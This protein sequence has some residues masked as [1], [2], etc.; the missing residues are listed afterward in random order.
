MARH[1]ARLALLL[2]TLTSTG[3]AAD[4][5]DDGVPDALDAY[6]CDEALAGNAW[7]P[8][9]GQHGMLL[10]EDQW[11]SRGDLD[12]NDVGLAYN[13]LFRTNA[14]GQ[15]VSVRASFNLLAAGGEIRHGLG[16]ALPLPRNAVASATRRVGDGA[17]APLTPTGDDLYTVVLS[18]DSRELLGGEAGPV[19]SRAD[20]PRVDSQV[21][22]VDLTLQAPLALAIGDAPFDVHIFRTA[23]PAHE[24]HRPQFP[25]T[26]AIR[27]SLFGSAQDGSGGGRFFVDTDGLPF[28]LVVPSSA[29]FPREHEA[30]QQ[31]FPDIVGFAQSDGETH[32]D[33]Y[34]TN[35]QTAFAYRDSLGRTP[36]APQLIALPAVDQSCLVAPSVESWVHLDELTP[37]EG[38]VSN[39]S[40]GDELAVNWAANRAY[41][42]G[43]ASDASG[44]A[45][46]SFPLATMVEDRQAVLSTVLQQD[47]Y[48]YPAALHSDGDGTLYFTVGFT[49][50]MPIIQVNSVTWTEAARFGFQSNGLENSPLRFV[51]T[52]WMASL[53]GAIADH[54]LTG[55]IL[56]DVGLLQGSPFS[57][58]WGEG[59]RV[60]EGRIAGLASDGSSGFVLGSDLSVGH[61]AL[62][63]YR[64]GLL[65]PPGSTTPFFQFTRSATFMPAQLE[66][67]AIGFYGVA[68]G[69][70]YDATDGGLIF[71]VTIANG[72]VAGNART[73]KWR[74]GTGDIAWDVVTPF[75]INYDG[76]FTSQNRLTRPRWAQMRGNRLIQLD[77]RDGSTMLDVTL[78]F[79]EG[80]AQ[81]YDAETNRLLVR[82]TSGWTRIQ[83]AP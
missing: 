72:S 22:T 73:I 37:A 33:F 1:A 27:T 21:L 15:V 51:R 5:D 18:P 24:I 38:G 64:L 6:P 14:S 44:T 41:F 76:P 23:D 65:G 12:F 62:A 57:Y 25:G 63:I 83:L 45:L 3:Y 54:I 47:P 11:P 9:Q 71:Q 70:I 7:A 19:N 66:P 46:R 39:G 42:I 30:I 17:P 26:R 13:Y 2:S 77:T 82:T 59:E 61:T 31:L 43:T 48:F 34:Q 79:Q 80:G 52:R 75:R 67:G 49:N 53:P 60:L 36:R 74:P 55:S 20:R 69:L 10:F 40:W 56:T 78:P 50:S 28:A 32:Q 8:A 4:A 58:A 29:E 81:A 35:V 68:G 16:L